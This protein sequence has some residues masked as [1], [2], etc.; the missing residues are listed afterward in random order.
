MSQITRTLNFQCYMIPIF[1]FD[2][3]ECK[4]LRILLNPQCLHSLSYTEITS[5]L[6][7]TFTF[8]DELRPRDSKMVGLGHRFE[9]VCLQTG[10]S[11]TVRVRYLTFDMQVGCTCR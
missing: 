4:M 8:L 10:I 9:C 3:R 5:Y 7:K 2:S 1:R 11:R 6:A